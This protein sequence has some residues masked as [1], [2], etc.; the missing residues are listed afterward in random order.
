MQWAEVVTNFQRL[1]NLWHKICRRDFCEKDIIWD[2]LVASRSRV[3]AS[4]PR[5][6]KCDFFSHG[7]SFLHPWQKQILIHV[8]GSE[9]GVFEC[10]SVYRCGFRELKVLLDELNWFWVP[11]PILVPNRCIERIIQFVLVSFCPSRP[12]KMLDKKRAKV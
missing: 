12:G 1:N 2:T 3:G 8:C 7:P 6:S 10:V 9:I 4:Q 11:F 5:S